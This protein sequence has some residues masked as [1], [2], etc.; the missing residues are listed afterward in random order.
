MIVVSSG[1]IIRMVEQHEHGKVSGEM[2]KYIH[3]DL[4]PGTPLRSDVEFAI[5]YHDYAWK[6][7]DQHPRLNDETGA[8]YSFTDYPLT[9]KLASYEKGIDSV[10]NH[11]AYAGLLCSLHYSSFFSSESTNPVIKS[12]ISREMNRRKQLQSRNV[13]FQNGEILDC[14]FKW[15]QFCDDLSLYLCMNEP[16]VAKED[17]VSWFQNGFRQTFPF[18]PGGM[19]A[20]WKDPYTIG[21]A[22]FPFKETFQV[23]LPYKS[24]NKKDFQQNDLEEIYQNTEFSM[25]TFIISS[26]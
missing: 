13:A 26:E 14:H 23:R 21:V 11:S 1:E 25:F 10:Q 6:E 15:L 5:S 20:N 17:E 12:F 7:I 16:G 8:P 24:F 2:A 9:A 18:A 19:E 4:F 22:P 3:P